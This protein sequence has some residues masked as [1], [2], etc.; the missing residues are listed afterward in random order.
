MAF[1]TPEDRVYRITDFQVMAAQQVINVYWYLLNDPATPPS[2]PDVLAAFNTQV[3]GLLDNEQVSTLS[4]E[5]VLV[6]LMIMDTDVT[7]YE[8]AGTGAGANVAAPHPGFVAVGVEL[9]VSSR[10]TRPGGKRIAGLAEEDTEDDN[11][12]GTALGNWIVATAGMGDDLLTSVG[13]NPFPVVIRRTST[14]LG[15]TIDLPMNEWEWQPVT[16]LALSTT[17]RS[18]VSRRK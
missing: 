5:S 15:V 16:G 12:T 9:R 3:A 8:A 17:V 6:E 18:Q 13:D 14:T 4:H 1:L 10:V 7:F 2:L 11:L